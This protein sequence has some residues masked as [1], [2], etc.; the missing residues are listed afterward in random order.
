MEGVGQVFSNHISK[1]SG[2]PPP[3][4]VLF[5]QSLNY[6]VLT[7]FS[8]DLEL[9]SIT[10]TDCVLRLEGNAINYVLF[11]ASAKITERYKMIDNKNGNT[12]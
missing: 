7:Y 2:P 11:N 8:N 12:S 4:P 1:C 5:D 10:T 6:H 3:L 9:S